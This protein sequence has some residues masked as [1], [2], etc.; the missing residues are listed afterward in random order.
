MTAMY[1]P[2]SIWI[3]LA[4]LGVLVASCMVFWAHVQRWTVHHRWA[5]MSEWAARNRFK[6]HRPSAS[7]G[8]PAAALV[9]IPL[10]T[11][12]LPPPTACIA[13]TGK[14]AVILQMDAP[15]TPAE[16]A[17]GVIGKNCRW[18]VLVR[19]IESEWAPTAL[20][21]L[22]HTVS[23]VDLFALPGLPSLFPGDRFTVHGHSAAAARSL[24]KSMLRA[25]MPHDLA[26]ILHGRRLI[27]DFSHRP[28]DE[29]ELTRMTG[30]AE[31][32]VAHLPAPMAASG[33]K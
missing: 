15:A 6:L 18:N 11:L 3:L 21:P 7:G 1:A 27:I 25:L 10:A 24:V 31:Q 4:L 32:L 17:S 12:T 26:L 13:L 23:L 19:E 29:I 14:R 28:F 22:E 16:T 2:F 20:R 9:P 5:A 33:K 30:L 8:R